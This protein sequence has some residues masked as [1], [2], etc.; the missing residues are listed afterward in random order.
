[1]DRYIFSA[2]YNTPVVTAALFY[3]EIK[4]STTESIQNTTDITTVAGSDCCKWLLKTTKEDREE[5]I[6]VIL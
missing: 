2:N 5:E 4:A 1:M 6:M 3:V